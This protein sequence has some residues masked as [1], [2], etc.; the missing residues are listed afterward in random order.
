MHLQEAWPLRN[1][2]HEN[3]C[4]ID[5]VFVEKI[6]LNGVECFNVNLVMKYFKEGDFSMFLKRRCTKDGKQFLT[7]EEALS[8]M[9]QMASGLHYLHSKNLMHRDL[10]PQNIFVSKEQELKIGGMQFKLILFEFLCVGIIYFIGI[11]FDTHARFWINERNAKF[12][13]LHCDWYFEIFSKFSIY[14]HHNFLMTLHPNHHH[15]IIFSFVQTKGSRNFEST[16][17]YLQC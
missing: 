12:I 6:L 1:L 10:K 3:L 7:Q 14:I 16:T 11:A 13:Y 9:K 5:D 2:S 17:L 4:S 15:L 8:F